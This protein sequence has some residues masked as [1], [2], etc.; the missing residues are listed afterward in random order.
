MDMTSK[1]AIK[2]LCLMR[3]Y[4]VIYQVRAKFGEQALGNDSSQGGKG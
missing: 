3:L 2:L 4:W 1:E